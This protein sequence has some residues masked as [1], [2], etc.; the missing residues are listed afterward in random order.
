V[1]GEADGIVLPV[2]TAAEEA[3]CPAC[4]TEIPAPAASDA[5]ALPPHADREA[6]RARTRRAMAALCEAVQE[7][8]A[9]GMTA[10]ASARA[11]RIHR[12][13]ARKDRALAAAPERRPVWRRPSILAPH[14][15]TSWSAGGR[16]GAT[17]W[18][19]GASSRRG[20]T[21]A[22]TAERKPC[23]R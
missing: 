16:D 11:L 17:P 4:A 10:S 20:A 1:T 12:H 21:R 9:Q 19:C 14:H 15:P 22:R 5:L 8:A 13:T 7:L 18:A 6:S 2:R 3:P 23:S